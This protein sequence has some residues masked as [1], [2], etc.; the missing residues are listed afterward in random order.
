MKQ[1]RKLLRAL[2]ALIPD[3]EKTIVVDVGA[4]PLDI[5]PYQPLVQTDQAHVFAFEPDPRAY[6]A[7]IETPP[8]NMTFLNDAVGDGKKHTLHVCKASYM[9]SLLRPDP[10]AIEM[11]PQMGRGLEVVDEIEVKTKALDRMKE[12]E[13]IDVLKIDIQGGELSVF[14][15]AKKKL[16]QALCVQSEVSFF[17]IYEDQPGFG[18]LDVE[19]R[20]RGLL[21]HSMPVIHR[22]PVSPLYARRRFGK[23]FLDG[24]IV[25]LRDLRKMDELSD[26]QVKQMAVIGAGFVGAYDVTARCL[27]ELVNRSILVQSELEE[28]LARFPPEAGKYV[29]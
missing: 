17:P 14:K 25:Y 20:R 15:N 2:K 4:N 12:I 5:P 19:L 6:E 11:F 1:R 23:Q 26:D 28:F 9:S 18:A 7:L 10:A 16:S 24:D 21:P 27:R 13:R 22:N 8:E 3:L 29:I